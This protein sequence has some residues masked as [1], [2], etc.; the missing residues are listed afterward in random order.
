[1][2]A[3]IAE[4]SA[5]DTNVPSPHG[6]PCPSCGCPV[7]ADDRFCPACGTTL[8]GAPTSSVA[9]PPDGGAAGRSAVESLRPPTNV[10]SPIVMAEAA[11]PTGGEAGAS[12][13]GTVI[14]AESPGDGFRY[15][16]CEGC[17]SEVSVDPDQRAYVCPFCDSAYVVEFSPAETNRQ[18]PEFVIGFGV[19]K[20][21]ARACFQQ[22]IGEGGWFRPG[23]LRRTASIDRL[24][25]VYL[26]FWT[27]AMQTDSVWRARIGEYW[28]RTETYTTTGANGKLETRTRQVR[29]TEWWDLQGRHHRYY[30]GYMVSGSRGLTQEEA[31]RIGPFNLPAL[32][33]YAPHYLA[34]WAAEEYSVSAVEALQR[35]QQ[36][37]YRRERR[38]VAEFLPGDCHDSLQV[39]TEFRKVTS[40]LCLLPVYVVA[41][42]Y[43]GRLYRFLVNGQTGRVTGE[44]PVS[45]ARIAIAIGVGLA[46]IG[47]ALLGALLAAQLGR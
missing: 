45:W 2:T 18:P 17:S 24:R 34:G 43:G 31:E 47:L 23:D 40:D 35:C 10:S 36:E 5:V 16:R 22:W 11:D 6:R 46:V 20:E 32:R 9:E 42:R 28:Y 1:M 14:A 39:S 26:P 38:H 27:F 33:R 7:E 13:A 21:R 3:S 25:G 30:S 44:R 41:Y 8:G 12:G 4:S 19:D 29:E 15:F 37:F